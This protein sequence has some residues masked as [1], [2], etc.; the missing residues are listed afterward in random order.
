M[1]WDYIE[2]YEKY[3]DESVWG[4]AGYNRDGVYPKF[5][6]LLIIGYIIPE[7]EVDISTGK[8]YLLNEKGE[9]IAEIDLNAVEHGYCLADSETLEDAIEWLQRGLDDRGIWKV[10]HG[11]VLDGDPDEY[12]C[13]G[14]EEW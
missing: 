3:E 13:V 4:Y 8:T 2:I 12:E 1:E 6:G 7:D 5:D 10:W 9:M 11:S 14:I